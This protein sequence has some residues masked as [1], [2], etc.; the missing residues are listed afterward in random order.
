[1]DRKILRNVSFKKVFAS[2]LFGFI[3]LI[4]VFVGFHPSQ[5]G[6]TNDTG[7]AAAVVADRLISLQEFQQA[8]DNRQQQMEAQL[9][10]LPAAQRQ[11][12]TRMLRDQVL[13]GLISSELQSKVAED[14]GLVGSDTEVREYILKIPYLSKDGRFDRSRYDSLLQYLHLSPSEFESK[15]RKEIRARKLSEVFSQA[16]KKVEGVDPKKELGSIQ[17]RLRYFKLNED[18]MRKLVRLDTGLVTKWAADPAN[19]GLIKEEYEKRKLDFIEPE[20]AKTKQIVLIKADK[21]AKAAELKAKL[22]PATFSELAKTWSDDSLTANRGGEMGLVAKGT[23]APELESGIIDAP[24]NEVQ[25]PFEA[26]GKTYFFLV[27]EKV[28]SA[29][30]PLDRIKNEIASLILENKKIDEAKLKIIKAVKEDLGIAAVEESLKEAGG[31]FQSTGLFNLATETVPGLGKVDSFISGLPG[32]PSIG[33]VYPDVV[34]IDGEE[35][36]IVFDEIKYG[37]PS[38]QAATPVAKN[39]FGDF[40]FESMAAS[41]EVFKRW[42]EPQ[43]KSVRVVRNQRLLSVNQ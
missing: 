43:V 38:A 21:K 31:S 2:I 25:G 14:L 42:F 19:E 28:P 33:K 3:A 41:S 24:I 16:F 17:M 30:K 4:F 5:F 15:I 29:V 10:Q 7:G 11:E 12:Q 40:D 18:S 22:T 36:I 26:K 37:D 35:T 39:P 34:A 32:K 27:E 20:R 1:M 8:L 23:L 9:N 13:E 6:A